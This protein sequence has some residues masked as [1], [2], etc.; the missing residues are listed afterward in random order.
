MEIEEIEIKAET[1]DGDN[2][3]WFKIKQ[4]YPIFFGISINTNRYKNNLFITQPYMNTSE[5]EEVLKKGISGDK[6]VYLSIE[7]LEELLEE[8]KKLKIIEAI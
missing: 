5:L 6:I 1:A 7:E 2:V 4:S 8:A 3:K